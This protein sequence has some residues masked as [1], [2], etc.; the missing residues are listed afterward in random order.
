MKYHYG[1]LVTREEKRERE[2]LRVRVLKLPTLFLLGYTSFGLRTYQVLTNKASS[3]LFTNVWYLLCRREHGTFTMRVQ[4]ASE[5]LSGE[6][7]VHRPDGIV[8]GVL[9]FSLSPATSSCCKVAIRAIC[10][11]VSFYANKFVWKS[12]EKIRKKMFCVAN[13]WHTLIACYILVNF[14]TRVELK[15]FFPRSNKLLLQR[16]KRIRTRRHI[17]RDHG[18]GAQNELSNR[19]FACIGVV[20]RASNLLSAQ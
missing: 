5:I 19:L 10:A 1:K 6:G 13:V 11:Y 8:Q 14:S 15:V 7:I 12:S 3:S 16:S 18:S 20:S 17:H 4:K 2:R 9:H